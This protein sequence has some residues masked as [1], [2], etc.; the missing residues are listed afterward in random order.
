MT[1]ASSQVPRLV[2]LALAEH[3]GGL[4]ADLII[5]TGL[6][7][8]R[9]DWEGCGIGGR[10]MGFDR[11]SGYSAAETVAG[12]LSEVESHQRLQNRACSAQP[13]LEYHQ[14]ED[15]LVVVPAA[16]VVVL[17]QPTY[18]FGHQEAV[19]QRVVGEQRVT[20]LA[21]Q[22]VPV[23]PVDHVAGERLLGPPDDLGR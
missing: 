20:Q 16:G 10:V 6:G 8:S 11:P 7:L 21:G 15:H 12:R 4:A 5:Y 14:A 13:F 23:P 9:D 19:H 18:A 22:R 2:E 17:D 1:Y 3:E